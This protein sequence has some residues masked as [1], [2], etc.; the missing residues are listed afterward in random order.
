MAI[1]E[2]LFLDAVTWV[3]GVLEHHVEDAEYD[4]YTHLNKYDIVKD[5]REHTPRAAKYSDRY[6]S[7]VLGEAFRDVYGGNVARDAD[8]V[9]SYDKEGISIGY[10]PDTDL[11]QQSF[12]GR[13]KY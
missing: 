12:P 11:R 3:E 6:L 5:F 2:D 1:N 8:A 7:Y 13:P 10:V 9:L 4:R